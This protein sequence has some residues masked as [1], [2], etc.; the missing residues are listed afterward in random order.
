MLSRSEGGFIPGVTRLYEK[1]P[2]ERV[3]VLIGGGGR[4]KEELMKLTQ[5]LITVDSTTGS[6]IIEP[7]SSSTPLANLLK[8]RDVVRAIASGFSPEKAFKLLDED[9][10]IMTIDLKLYVGDKPNHLARVKGRIIGEEGKARRVIEELT[11]SDIVIYEDTVAIIGDYESANLA[12]EAI[13]MLI[14]G[15]K[16]STVYKFLER[17]SYTLKRK[18]LREL[19]R[20]N[21]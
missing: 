7:A 17:E 20:K 18:H 12:K 2:L 15:R 19:W 16:H 14:R 10:V 13:E 6:V 8:A 3:G 5:T 9:Y 21:I 1:I 4:V 11:G